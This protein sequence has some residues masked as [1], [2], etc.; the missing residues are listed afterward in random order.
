[1]AIRFGLVVQ[2]SGNQRCKK[3]LKENGIEVI[4]VNFTELL[5]GWGAVH[6]ATIFL[7]RK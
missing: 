2:P 3:L 7:K 1:M 5:K 4:T 6:C